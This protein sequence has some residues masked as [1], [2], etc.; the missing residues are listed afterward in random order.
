MKRLT[1]C[2]STRSL[3]QTAVIVACLSIH[4]YSEVQPTTDASKPASKDAYLLD[5]AVA[6]GKSN[7]QVVFPTN[8]LVHLGFIKTVPANVAIKATL[9]VGSFHG[10]QTGQ[11]LAVQP[12]ETNILFN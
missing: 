11:T 4:G 7:F 8:G 5:L 6:A 12:S 1:R 3:C 10:E 2:R 9:I